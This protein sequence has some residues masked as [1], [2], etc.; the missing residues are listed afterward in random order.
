MKKILSPLLIISAIVIFVLEVVFITFVAISLTKD[1]ADTIFW[2]WTGL[3][4]AIATVSLI[5]GGIIMYIAD[6]DMGGEGYIM[7]ISYGFMI[8]LLTPLS[9]YFIYRYNKDKK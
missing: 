9:V 3:L 7:T 1:N 5:I 4:I 8:P 6:R 2:T